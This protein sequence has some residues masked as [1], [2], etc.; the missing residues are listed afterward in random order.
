MVVELDTKE[1]PMEASIDHERIVVKRKTPITLVEYKPEMID[2]VKVVTGI[3]LRQ[4]HPLVRGHAASGPFFHCWWI[5]KDLACVDV[6]AGFQ[7]YHKR[8]DRNELIRKWFRP[9]G[10]KVKQAKEFLDAEPEEKES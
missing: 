2:G 8:V 4:D 5:E 1:G 7:R 6:D 10:L 9:L 3:T